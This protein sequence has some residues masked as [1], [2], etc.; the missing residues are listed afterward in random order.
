MKIEEGRARI[1]G[2]IVEYAGY[3][4]IGQVRSI[5]EDDFLLLP[6]KGI[7][8]LTD[9]L[10]GEEHGEVASATALESIKALV[11]SP[12]RSVLLPFRKKNYSLRQ[13]I[14]HANNSVYEKRK[15]LRLNTATTIVMVQLDDNG[16]EVANVGDSRLYQWNGRSLV[17]CTRDH[18]LIEELYRDKTLS[19]DQ[20][21]N[22]PQRHI[23]T[24]ALGAKKQ[25]QASLGK[26]DIQNGNL[27]L[28]CSDG[29]TTMLTQQEMESIFRRYHT[30]VKQIGHALITAAN[31]AGGRD[32]ITVVLLHMAADVGH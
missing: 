15:A 10:G 2:F 22:H 9:G 11:S 24:R 13:I 31:D 30:D 21:D 8:C 6:D 12:G 18:S 7:F 14:R 19:R 25:I 16:A 32:N 26:I 4:D 27:V 17:Q 5:N 20:A 1:G 28:L 3:S 23:I 29:L